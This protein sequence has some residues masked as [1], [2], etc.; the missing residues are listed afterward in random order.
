MTSN[1]PA[2]GS[3]DG[4]AGAVTTI[5]VGAPLM[6]LINVFTVDPSKQQELVD[7]LVEA[8]KAR[9]SKLPGFVSANIHRSHD[10]KHVVNY[11][12]W[13]ARE[14]FEAA[15]RNPEAKEHMRKAGAL[16]EFN[17]IICEVARVDHADGV[18][19]G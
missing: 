2:P 5:R 15:L 4:S 18:A 17:P 12:Q 11:A 14:D 9:M 3:N 16:A 10:G 13:L 1:S 6:T 8:T 19:H 7:L